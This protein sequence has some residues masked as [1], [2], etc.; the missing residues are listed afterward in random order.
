M[1]HASGLGER[2][3]DGFRFVLNDQE[4]GPG[5]AFRSAAPLLPISERPLRNAEPTRELSLGQLETP[6]NAPDVDLGW[7]MNTVGRGIRLAASDRTRLLR[8]VDQS[9][10]QRGH[11]A[12]R[13][14][15][16]AGTK[17]AANRCLSRASARQA[18]AT[19][20]GNSSFFR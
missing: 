3:F 4:K 2:P 12:G 19:T 11:A 10:A 18:M 13:A 14:I 15:L 17:C 1:H 20:G 16:R 7:N 8:G 6:A 9:L 5:R